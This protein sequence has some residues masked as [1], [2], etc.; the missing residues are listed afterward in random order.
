[1]LHITNDP[2]LF[3]GQEDQKP[4]PIVTSDGIKEYFVD[5]IID[6]HCHNR[7]WQYLICWVGYG[8][9]HDGWLSHTSLED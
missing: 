1:M 6:S 9:K 3:P 2:I 8:P 7:G 5:E 4:P